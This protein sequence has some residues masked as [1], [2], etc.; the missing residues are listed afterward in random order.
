MIKTQGLTHIHLA[1]GDLERSLKFYC[2][3]FGMQV[4]FWDGPSMVFLNT[5]GSVDTIT[6]RQAAAEE[7]VGQGGGVAH[8]GFRLEQKEELDS[9]IEEIVQAGGLLVQRGEHQPGYPYAYVSD[10]DGYII[11]L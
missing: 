7:P 5:P 3:V 2:D 1:V 6:L 11:E 9:A 8:F 4:R 10:P